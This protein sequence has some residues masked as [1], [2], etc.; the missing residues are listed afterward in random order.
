ME[1]YHFLNV[2]Q[3]IAKLRTTKQGL[4]Q[5]EAEK[6]H[7]KHGPNALPE[8]KKF[9][10]VKIFLSQFKSALIYIL[11]IAVVISFFLGEITDGYVILSAVIINV[12]IGY[13]QEAKAEQSLLMIKQTIKSHSLVVRDGK[14]EEI[15]SNKLVVG[16]LIICHAGDKISADA[17]IINS[18]NDFA[19]N[20]AVL[21]GESYPIKKDNQILFEDTPLAD[22]KNMLYTGTIVSSGR[23]EAIVC[24]VGLETEM[25]KIASLIKET[26]EEK[27]PLQTKLDKFSKTLGLIVLFISTFLFIYGLNSG[28]DPKEMFLTAVA[29]AVSAI[30]EGLVVAVTAILA[31][32][33]QKILKKKA[34]VRKLVATETLGSINY[35]CTDKTGTLTIGDMRVVKVITYNHNLSHIEIT[36]ELQEQQA[37]PLK[38]LRIGMLS[39]DAHAEN[40]EDVS[41]E[42]I[43]FGTPTEKALLLAGMQVGL[44]Q[45]DLKKKYPRLDEIPFSSNLKYMITL[46]EF[47][48]QTNHL[49][50]KGAPEKIFAMCSQIDIDKEIVH[51][52]ENKKEKIYQQFEQLSSSGLRLLAFAYKNSDK[53]IKQISKIPNA[54]NDYIFLGFVAIKDPLRAE[55]KETIEICRHAGITPVMITGDHKL[56]AIAIAKELGMSCAD[57]NIL[58]GEELSYLPDHEFKKIITRISVYA[59]VTPADK[60]RIVK[61]LQA[62]NCVVAMTGDGINDAPA[63]KA[64]DIGIAL[65]SGTDVAK[66]TADLVLLDN[67]FTT[68]IG[69]IEQGRVI[70]K[71]IKTTLFYL[72]SD[73]FTELVLISLALITGSPLPV[74]ASQILWV[75]LIDDTLPSLALTM[76][77]GDAN[78]LKEPPIPRTKSILDPQSRSLVFIISM[79]TGVVN[80][81]LF[82]WLLKS[83]SLEEARTLI[84]INIGMD[85]LLYIFSCRDLNKP[86]WH[87]GFF[88]N[89]YLVVA[90][91]VGLILEISSVYLPFLQKVLHTT[92]LS[93]NDWGIVVIVNISIVFC[94]EIAKWFVYRKKI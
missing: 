20:E 35:I 30:P 46:N 43:V 7:F 5:V 36:P 34:L 66:E 2:E 62:H 78:V 73:S 89:K 68:I 29:I 50:L 47:D 93:L 31:V 12:I 28:K 94:F 40:P 55:A 23:V 41:G 80:F 44:S 72:I 48:H 81:L 65:G 42:W 87:K 24:A 26:K 63:L 88:S 91:T 71:N 37:S 86:I 61:A 16:D 22:R 77:Q 21:T 13:L 75:N 14:E 82:L 51:F 6:R 33:M 56:T 38:L 17:R 25:G 76:E 70:Y 1:P 54:E 53:G 69:A 85:S 58:T 19:V 60:I 92:A 52:T 79:L 3:V 84:F 64:S 49:Y 90:I 11:L 67:N 15:E 74:L 57:K 10:R 9:S 18:Y 27:T 83:R 32:G 8:G 39:N 45:K 59:R 4:T